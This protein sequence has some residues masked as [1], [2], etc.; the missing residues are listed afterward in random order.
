MR[1]SVNRGGGSKC[2]LLNAIFPHR[3]QKIIGCQNVLIKM[4]FSIRS[5]K[6]DIRVC[7]YMENEV[8]IS[9]SS[10][11]LL[12]VKKVSFYQRKIRILKMLRYKSDFSRTQV[13]KNSDNVPFLY[14]A[15]HQVATYK[16]SSSCHKY[17][18]LCRHRKILQQSYFPY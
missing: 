7:S 2:N 16:A 11:Y 5:P 14:K 18:I 15:V 8:D 6:P 9:A 3:F 17:S 13:V 1:L 10:F 4:D 12:L